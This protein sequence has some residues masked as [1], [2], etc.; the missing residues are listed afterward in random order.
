MSHFTASLIRV[1][2]FTQI[3]FLLGCVSVGQIPPPRGIQSK[4]DIQK[5]AECMAPLAAGIKPGFDG[6]L[7][8]VQQSHGSGFLN[9]KLKSLLEAGFFE[10]KWNLYSR[11]DDLLINLTTDIRIPI[12]SDAGGS[13]LEKT[14]KTE[15][16]KLVKPTEDDIIKSAE[17]TEAYFR[18]Y[19]T[20]SVSQAPNPSILDADNKTKLQSKLAKVLNRK[21]DDPTLSK[22]LD[23]LAP[24]LQKIIGS[25]SQPL[26]DASGFV[27][28]DGTVYAFPGI[29]ESTGNGVSIDHNQIG[30]DFIRIFL[31]SIRDT[32]APLPV[33]SNSTA[34]WITHQY[35]KGH[36][37]YYRFKDDKVAELKF[38][39][40]QS[41]QDFEWNIDHKG[42]FTSFKGKIKPEE[43]EEI[44]ANARNAESLTA[45]AVGKA[46]RG[47]SWGS[48]NN[49]AVAKFIETAAGVLARQVS[50]RAQ[51]CE[52]YSK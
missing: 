36:H 3:I 33:L 1:I 32:Y 46:I 21:P 2:L 50:E 30:S 26:S 10:N 43:F 4:I 44:E 8:K 9:Q 42:H 31:E 22:A 20:K 7:S 12:H 23:E 28:R 19:F 5:F 14:I 18:A 47:G 15:A 49:E 37:K 35:D 51:W 13:S 25:I 39:S 45:E 40:D 24:E 52:L 17:R 6:L 11:L 29:A 27:G 16:D 41:E 48:L 38:S 34:A